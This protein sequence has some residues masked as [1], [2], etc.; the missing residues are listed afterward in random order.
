MLITKL[1]LPD[2]YIAATAL[3]YNIELFTLNL[4]DFIFIPNLKLY[5]P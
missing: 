2:A 1:S 5:Q 3:Y 4:K